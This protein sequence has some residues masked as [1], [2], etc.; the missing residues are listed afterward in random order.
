LRDLSDESQGREKPK[1]PDEQA[2]EMAHHLVS[3]M[4]SVS[5]RIVPI[6]ATGEI[7]NGMKVASD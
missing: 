1:S 6:G 3:R 5:K 4:E 7:N 2:L